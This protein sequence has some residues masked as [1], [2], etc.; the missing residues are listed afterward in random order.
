MLFE[1]LIKPLVI[2]L[3]LIIRCKDKKLGDVLYV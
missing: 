2:L 1:F 3:V